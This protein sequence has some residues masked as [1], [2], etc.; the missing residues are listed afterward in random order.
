RWIERE[1]SDPRTARGRTAGSSNTGTA[2]RLHAAQDRRSAHGTRAGD[3]RSGPDA[4][5]GLS[6]GDPAHPC[7]ASGRTADAVLLRNPG[8]VGTRIAA[9][10]HALGA[11]HRAG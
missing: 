2:G 7:R 5:H 6:A 3:G 1:G 10:L 9:A 8:E 11:S 4:G